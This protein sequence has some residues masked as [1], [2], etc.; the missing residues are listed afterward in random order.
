MTL[1]ECDRRLLRLSVGIC[2]GRW[3]LLREVRRAAPDG[4]PNRAWREAVLQ[5]HIFAG[6]PRVVEAYGILAE[7]GGLGEPEEDELMAEPDLF[8]RGRELFD[9][10]YSGHAERVRS[11][12][13]GYHPDFERWIEGHTYGRVLSRPGLLADK[14]ELL[15]V[16]CLAALGQ[17]RQLASHVRGGLHCGASPESLR[18][19]VAEVADLISTHDLRHAERVLQRFARPD[20]G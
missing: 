10:I 7:E 4:E 11:T 8:E 2:L 12:L 1:S 16:V 6:F 20:P 3:K 18:E 13:K 9:R 19:S 5:T 17:D 15:A 14:R